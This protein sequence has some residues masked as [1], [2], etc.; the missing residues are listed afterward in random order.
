MSMAWGS[1]LRDL[2]HFHVGQRGYHIMNPFKCDLCVFRKLSKV[3][4]NLDSA[5]DRLLLG[6]IWRMNLDVI[7]SRSSGTVVMNAERAR[8]G[9]ECSKL[10][11]LQG[12]YEDIEVYPSYDHCRYEVAA[13]IPMQSIKPGKFSADYTQ[14]QTI[15][16]HQSTF[17]NQI[18]AL[19]QPNARPVVSVDKKGKYQRITH[20]KT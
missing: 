7:W 18:R 12:P 8:M 14:F 15:R 11:D 5:T 3:D 17:G 1:Q 10:L 13:V 20:N 19:A 2:L 9:I 6:V 16:K 4:P